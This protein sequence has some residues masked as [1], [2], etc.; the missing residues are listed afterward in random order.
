MLGPAAL[1]G[2]ILWRAS[3]SPAT[4]RDTPR[5]RV[6]HWTPALVRTNAF[7]WV[8]YLAGYEL[9]F[10]GVLVLGLSHVLGPWP[11]LAAGTGLY[12]LQHLPRGPGECLGSL[13]M[14]I[15]F[16][17]MTLDTGSV[18]SAWLLHVF[19][20]VGAEAMVIRNNPSLATDS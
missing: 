8:V 13:P 5:L 7:G 12:V 11:A 9:L 15:V 6:P 16:G 4:W 10:R 3:K 17:L 14:G 20:A 1:L 2:P 19:I 18:Q